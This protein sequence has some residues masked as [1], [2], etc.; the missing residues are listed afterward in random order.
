MT[1]DK[2]IV[3]YTSAEPDDKT[4]EIAKEIASRINAD[5]LKI[6]L[7]GRKELKN[8]FRGDVD[9]KPDSSAYHRFIFGFPA[10]DP[11]GAPPI[12]EFIKQNKKAIWGKWYSVF[13][14]KGRKG[15]KKGF[16]KI[17]KTLWIDGFD[18]KLVV[19]EGID[20]ESMDSF[21]EYINTFS[22]WPGE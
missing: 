13:C 7:H 22:A 10:Y 17:A 15:A 20:G 19:T 6:S 4:E 3:Y 8:C 9:S 14:Y 1:T 21:C 12:T 16:S 18:A 5:L 2:L 11:D